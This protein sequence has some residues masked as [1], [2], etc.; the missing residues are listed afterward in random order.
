MVRQTVKRVEK[1]SH[2]LD[3]EC[4]WG[5]VNRHSFTPYNDMPVRCT[6]CSTMFDSTMFD[7]GECPNCHWRFSKMDSVDMYIE[8]HAIKVIHKGWTRELLELA[9]KHQKP[10]IIAEN[11]TVHPLD[12][13]SRNLMSY[14]VKTL[15][16][17]ERR[18]A[19]KLALVD[20]L[21]KQSRI[22]GL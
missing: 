2:L 12:D 1:S 4:R 22:S 3:E 16:E 17:A 11:H 8:S 18:R 14:T 15:R 6:A 20:Q 10:I 5:W 21:R 13:V 19:A 7:E 9:S